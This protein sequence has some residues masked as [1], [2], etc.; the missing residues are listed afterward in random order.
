MSSPTPAALDDSWHLRHQL[1]PSQQQPAIEGEAASA[2]LQH[3][4]PTVACTRGAADGATAPQQ[5]RKSGGR[6]RR[7]RP[8]QIV[9]T[10]MNLTSR[11]E[12]ALQLSHTCGA[13]HDVEAK[14]QVR[15]PWTRRGAPADGF[16]QQLQHQ[17]RAHVCV[18]VFTA[19][20]RAAAG[21]VGVIVVRR[22][23]GAGQRHRVVEARRKTLHKLRRRGACKTTERTFG[24]YWLDQQGAV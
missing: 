9:T 20:R 7:Q 17:P 14:Q 11:L 24:S 16:Q 19:W 13:V 8:T 23:E 21:C 10:T 3:S 22:Q 5:V 12:T 4:A 6:P 15:E 2:S 18:G 1:C